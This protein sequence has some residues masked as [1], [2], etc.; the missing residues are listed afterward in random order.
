M[1]A[2]KVVCKRST[3]LLIQARL[4]AWRTDEPEGSC[5]WSTWNK[6]NPNLFTFL[7]VLGWQSFDVLLRPSEGVLLL[8]SCS[9]S[10]HAPLL[11]GG[12]QR[13]S[14]NGSSLA[15]NVVEHT[16]DAAV[17][18]QL[19]TTDWTKGSC[20]RTFRGN[21]RMNE[22]AKKNLIF[23]AIRTNWSEPWIKVFYFWLW[24]SNV[25]MMSNSEQDDNC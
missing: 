21:D 11:E 14:T 25:Y 13:S 15:A 6:G 19:C 5:S 4:Y 18:F 23:F 1:R 8:G 9:C 7:A 24:S 2:N 17:P 3:P 12:G 22:S 16:V 20:S 10:G